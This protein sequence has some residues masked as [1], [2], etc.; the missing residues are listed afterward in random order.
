MYELTFW[1]DHSAWD[2]RTE[3]RQRIYEG[4]VF[5]NW[6]SLASN[7]FRAHKARGRGFYLIPVGADGDTPAYL[8]YQEL[9]RPAE[10][11]P[12]LPGGVLDRWLRDYPPERELVIVFAEADGGFVS[13]KAAARGFQWTPA[14]MHAGMPED[15]GKELGRLP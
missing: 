1:V 7:A 12:S 13:L 9:Y 14:V 15:L 3:Q 6:V 8:K 4:F 10:Q 2:S 11:A 5:R